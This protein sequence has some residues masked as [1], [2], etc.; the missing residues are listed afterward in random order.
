MYL[1]W[2]LSLAA[3]RLLCRMSVFCLGSR[4]HAARSSAWWII[5]MSTWAQHML[6]INYISCMYI[7]I[8]V[9]IYT[10]LETILKKKRPEANCCCMYAWSL[11]K[12]A[13]ILQKRRRI[14]KIAGATDLWWNKICKNQNLWELRRKG[15]QLHQN[16]SNYAGWK[17][18]ET[19]SRPEL[20]GPV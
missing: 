7:T 13:G 17:K 2:L 4:C 15:E 20:L 3:W 1:S 10:H 11:Y 18:W 5:L 19:S 9:Y 8:Y 14:F 16:W 6:H 12:I